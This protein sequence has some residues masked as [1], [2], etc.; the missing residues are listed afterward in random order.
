MQYANDEL[1]YGMGLELGLDLLAFGGEVFHS[2]IIH[3]LGVAYELL[4]RPEFI[5]VLKVYH[6][7]G[8]LQAFLSYSHFTTDFSWILNLPNILVSFSFSENVPIISFFIN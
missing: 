1:D 7:N 4:E 2:T 3:L 6:F 5:A 8:F